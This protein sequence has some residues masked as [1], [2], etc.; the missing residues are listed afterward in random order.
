M[1]G[2]FFP[3]YTVSQKGTIMRAENGTILNHLHDNNVNKNRKAYD[4]FS[5][6]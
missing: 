6:S 2:V 3:H 1:T 4:T 5:F